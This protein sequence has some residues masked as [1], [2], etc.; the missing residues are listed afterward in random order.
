MR[1]WSCRVNTPL[2]AADAWS[3]DMTILWMES[4][5]F[6]RCRM[7]SS[8]VFFDTSRYT[9]TCHMHACL[10]SVCVHVRVCKLGASAPA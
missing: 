7:R 3:P 10:K 6:A 8:I 2:N 1:M 4:F 9:V 5:C